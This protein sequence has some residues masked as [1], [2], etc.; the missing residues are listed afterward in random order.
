LLFGLN[1]KSLKDRFIVHL[2]S[3]LP[4]PNN[5][6]IFGIDFIGNLS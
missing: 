2:I 4:K 1:D 5:A 3:R 6:E